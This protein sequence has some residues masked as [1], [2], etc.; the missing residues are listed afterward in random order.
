Q[1]GDGERVWDESDAEAV[2]GDFDEGEADAV[3]GDGALVY[4][5]LGEDGRAREPDDLPLALAAPL[6]DAADAVDVPLDEMSA[7]SVAE[8]KGAF[9]VD[10]VAGLQLTEVGLRERLW[11]CLER[12]GI[13]LEVDDGEA[14]AIDSDAIAESRALD[15]RQGGDS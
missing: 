10:A 13:A 9:E 7:E 4:H 14:G 15:E 6:G 8:T 3:D 12:E 2:A 5:L 11:P 1:G